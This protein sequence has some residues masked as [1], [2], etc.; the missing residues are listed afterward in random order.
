MH[1]FI[2]TI[3][4]LSI[5]CEQEAAAVAIQIAKNNIP[6]PAMAS[7][8]TAQEIAGTLLK[9][10]NLTS[11]LSVFDQHDDSINVLRGSIELLRQ[12]QWTANERSA[13]YQ[14]VAENS[15]RLRLR[16]PAVTL[17]QAFNFFLSISDLDITNINNENNAEETQLTS[18]DNSIEVDMQKCVSRE[19]I[20]SMHE[21]SHD[22]DQ[23]RNI[24]DVMNAAQ[25]DH[26]TFCEDMVIA[27][28]RGFPDLIMLCTKSAESAA[29]KSK[30]LVSTGGMDDNTVQD[31]SNSLSLSEAH[32][33]CL[34]ALKQ[35]SMWRARVHVYEYVWNF[36]GAISVYL[37]T[38]SSNHTIHHA[39][40]LIVGENKS[41]K[42]HRNTDP[43]RVFEYIAYLTQMLR[44]RDR[45]SEKS[46]TNT[47]KLTNQIT[48]NSV[49]II[50]VNTEVNTADDNKKQESKLMQS[51]RQ[52]VKGQLHHLISLDEDRACRAIQ[53]L[54]ED[55]HDYERDILGSLVGYPRVQFAFMKYIARLSIKTGYRIPQ[56]MLPRFGSKPLVQ[57]LEL[58]C[59]FEPMQVHLFLQGMEEE[60]P[61]EVAIQICKRYGNEEGEAFLME[62]MGDPERALLL[63][64]SAA[65]ARFES[66]MENIDNCP[67]DLTSLL[68]DFPAAITPETLTTRYPTIKPTSQ[69]IYRKNSTNVDN[70]SPQLLNVLNRM[71]GFD[72]CRQMCRRNSL[73]ILKQQKQTFTPNGGKILR[74]WSLFFR[75]FYNFSCEL[76]T[77]IQQEHAAIL[78]RQQSAKVEMPNYDRRRMPLFKIASKTVTGFVNQ[79]MREMLLYIPHKQVVDQ[80]F[81]NCADSHFGELRTGLLAMFSDS[82][83]EKTMLHTMNKIMCG[84][85]RRTRTI[86]HQSRKQGIRIKGSELQRAFTAVEEENKSR[87]KAQPLKAVCIRDGPCFGFPSQDLSRFLSTKLDS[88]RRG[89]TTIN[90]NCK[91]VELTFIF[92]LNIMFLSVCNRCLLFS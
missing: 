29:L 8:I 82:K 12:R 89:T 63:L 76:K 35:R 66:L 53:T 7:F 92:C 22:S 28:M 73:R 31:R 61:L 24:K 75:E 59:Q 51:L 39:T 11:A 91:F 38:I 34:T 68:R 50:F 52:A 81:K 67:S 32:R 70:T 57:L 26:H 4:V 27:L 1:D 74:L 43:K 18:D 30:F 60:L 23:D 41:I 13:L 64:L 36:T 65:R 16:L 17:L 84:D 86:A 15:L 78:A 42:R 44:H 10:T 2:G 37:E 6:K 48:S 80:V 69:Q 90:L 79:L 46:T 85:I 72:I 54:F 3:R 33:D 25:D 56:D 47:T 21:Q 14:F 71:F 40:S 58:L 88:I 87:Q 77:Q 20:H 55:C 5:Y 45:G 19:R 9:L 49:P 62:R 83:F